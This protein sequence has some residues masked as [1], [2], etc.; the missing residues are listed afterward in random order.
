MRETL[1]VGQPFPQ[2]HVNVIALLFQIVLA[3]CQAADQTPYQLCIDRPTEMFDGRLGLICMEHVEAL[4][5]L[6]GFP[7]WIGDLSNDKVVAA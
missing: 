7:A 6:N 4:L 5:K 2:Q 3:W 1:S